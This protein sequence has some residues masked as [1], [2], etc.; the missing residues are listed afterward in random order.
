MEP[1]RR[2]SAISTIAVSLV[3]GIVG[4]TTVTGRPRFSGYATVDVLQLLASGMCFGIALVGLL[5]TVR[6]RNRRPD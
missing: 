6:E 3:V 4:L 5:R 1:S 2:K